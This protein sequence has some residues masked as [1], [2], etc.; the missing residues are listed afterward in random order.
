VAELADD[1]G[2]VILTRLATYWNRLGWRDTL[3]REE[4]P[5][6][7]I[8]MRSGSNAVAGALAH[9]KRWSTD[10]SG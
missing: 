5:N 2:L 7:N 1:P 4:M 9:H 8:A 3:A 10:G 6:R